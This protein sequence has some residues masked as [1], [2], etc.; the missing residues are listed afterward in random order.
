VIGAR[1]PWITGA[2]TALVL[3]FLVVPLV[4]VVLFSFHASA[5]LSFPFTGFSTR[6]Y[7]EVLGS[8]D[9]QQAAKTSL[10]V[11]LITALLTFAL[12][13][14]AAYAISRMTTRWRGVITLLLFVPITLPPL[15]LGIALLSAFSRAHTELSLTTVAIAHTIVAFPYFFLVARVALDRIDPLLEQTAADLGA[16]PLQAFRRVTLPQVLPV[17]VGAAILAFMVSLDEFIVTF[18]VAGDQTTLPL[19]LF[20]RLRQS[21]DPTINVIS[22]LLMLISV[23]LWVAAFTVGVRNERRRAR[24]RVAAV[25]A[26]ES[27]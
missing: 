11:A 27:I 24:I 18:F 22:S 4:I 14:P 8:E 23:V 26:G 21:I 1:R 7:E 15:F 16:T 19:L 17:L 5:G 9:F 10:L 25:R 12:A 13:T 20:A 6:W 2:I 3:V